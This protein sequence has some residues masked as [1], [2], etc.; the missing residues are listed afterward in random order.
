ML[1]K[2]YFRPNKSTRFIILALLVSL[3]MHALFVLMLPQNT[4]AIH[5]GSPTRVSVSMFSANKAVTDKAHKTINQTPKAKPIYV[6]SENFNQKNQNFKAASASKTA[7]ITT[8]S[9]QKNKL[10]EKKTEMLPELRPIKKLAEKLKPE[11]AVIN[12]KEML[13]IPKEVSSVKF[14][15]ATVEHQDLAQ[16]EALP[17]NTNHESE[18]QPV[19]YEIGSNNNP[20]PNYPSIAVKRGWQGQVI[21]GVHV[22]PDGSIEHLT[23]VK[24]T[25]YGVLNF[26]AYETV[27]TSWQFKPLEG[28][29][30]LSKSSYIEVP[31]TFNIANR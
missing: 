5:S 24:S 6:A 14:V 23:F 16:T 1:N 26:E 27:R 9:V 29:D 30:N 4:D 11:V 21:L 28:N 8:K 15:Q 19:R 7:K 13:M 31:I 17:S 25:D 22:K 12:K 2:L 10:A 18:P 3:F 20:K